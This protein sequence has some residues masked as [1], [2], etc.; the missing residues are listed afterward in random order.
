MRLLEAILGCFFFVMELFLDLEWIELLF[1][2][3]WIVGFFLDETFWL[4]V[5]EVSFV[6][7]AKA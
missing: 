6:V 2:C 7:F 4:D 5:Y 3:C 1:Y